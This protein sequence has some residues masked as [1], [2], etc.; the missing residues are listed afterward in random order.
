MPIQSGDEDHCTRPKAGP[1]PCPLADPRRHPNPG[2][3]GP[4]RADGGPLRPGDAETGVSQPVGVQPLAIVAQ[5]ERLAARDWRR[6][7][8][9]HPQTPAPGADRWSWR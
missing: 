9:V 6:V 7:C 8:S 2:H 5:T 1:V 3:L 4:A